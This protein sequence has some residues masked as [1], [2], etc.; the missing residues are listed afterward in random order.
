MTIPPTTAA[1]QFTQIGQTPS[2]LSRLETAGPTFLHLVDLDPPSSP[3]PA[4]A[5]PEEIPHDALGRLAVLAE[6]ED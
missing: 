5:S 1:F 3:P 4:V 2:L 6:L